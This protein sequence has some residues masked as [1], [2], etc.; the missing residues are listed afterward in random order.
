MWLALS[1][2]VIF[3]WRND[4]PRRPV[5]AVRNFAQQPAADP[6]VIHLMRGGARIQ[7]TDA[8]DLSILA[9]RWWG[10]DLLWPRLR[11]GVGGVQQ[12]LTACLQRD[13]SLQLNVGVATIEHPD[14]RVDAYA[15]QH[16]NA[17][18][19]ARTQTAVYRMKRDALLIDLAS[20][21]VLA[22]VVAL[23]LPAVW[24][25]ARR[26]LRRDP[27]LCRSCGYDVRYSPDRCPECGQP[28]AAGHAARN[29]PPCPSGG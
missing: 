3:A 15:L 14:G 13:P 16:W 6:G 12:T 4:L 25:L 28:V 29:L 27:N 17:A 11:H 26:R 10:V 22:A 19:Q 21:F 9:R 8:Y 1:A 18:L 7:A 23:L 2:C 5:Q 24:N 20:T